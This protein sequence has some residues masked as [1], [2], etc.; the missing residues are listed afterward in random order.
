MPESHKVRLTSLPAAPWRN[1]R[2]A[3]GRG[4]QIDLLLQAP[5]SVCVV[6]IKRKAEIGENVADEVQAKV[7]ALGTPRGTSIRTALVYEGSL[8]PRIEA[9]GYFDFLV[10]AERLFEA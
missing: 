6:E 5:R 1:A 9:D 7:A 8:S 3:N 2:T 10:P 4:C